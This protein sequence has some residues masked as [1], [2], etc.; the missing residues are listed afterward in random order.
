M[1]SNVCVFATNVSK[2]R[3]IFFASVPGTV[4]KEIMLCMWAFATSLS[5]PYRVF[6]IVFALSYPSVEK[7][8]PSTNARTLGRSSSLRYDSLVIGLIS[9][10]SIS[11]SNCPQ[12]L[13]QSKWVPW[14]LDITNL[15]SLAELHWLADFVLASSKFKLSF[16]FQFSLL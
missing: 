7:G 10:L 8:R 11:V 5:F 14:N 2:K 1:V 3:L 4:G 12:N 15:G 6:R 16:H 13:C 9:A